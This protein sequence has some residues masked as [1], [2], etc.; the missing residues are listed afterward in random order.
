MHDTPRDVAY[1]NDFIQ[2][3]D[4]EVFSETSSPP[5]DVPIDNVL[6]GNGINTIKSTLL[7]FLYKERKSFSHVLQTLELNSVTSSH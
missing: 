3:I 2:P 6:G 5:L 7:R 1:G 4:R